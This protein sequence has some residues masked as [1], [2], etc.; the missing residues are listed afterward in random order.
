MSGFQHHDVSPAKHHNLSIHHDVETTICIGPSPQGMGWN[1]H[2][3]HCKRWGT[4]IPIPCRAEDDT[5]CLR[6]L[7]W[8]WEGSTPPPP[9]WVSPEVPPA[10]MQ[11]GGTKG[12]RYLTSFHLWDGTFL[13][14]HLFWLLIKL[15]WL[16]WKQ[17]NWTQWVSNSLL[18]IPRCWPG[19]VSQQLT[20]IALLTKMSP[21]TH[22]STW[23]DSLVGEKQLLTSAS[24]QVFW[25]SKYA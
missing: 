18:I 17:V 13:P 21:E 15:S 11:A 25:E 20:L 14:G 3:S 1:G 23:C 9:S 16:Q 12:Q 10:H 19:I 4:F 7:A 22:D 5:A 24:D 6:F 2:S 8:G